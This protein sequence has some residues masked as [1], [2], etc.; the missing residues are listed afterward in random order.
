MGSAPRGNAPSGPAFSP[1]SISRRIASGREG[2]SGCTRR[3][4]SKAKIAARPM[5]TF[6]AS[7]SAVGRPL[8]DFLA[9]SIDMLIL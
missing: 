1:A 5:R 2:I 3:Q 4:S 7:V 9:I 6:T 8:A